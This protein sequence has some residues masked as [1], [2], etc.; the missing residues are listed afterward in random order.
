[1]EVRYMKL[2]SIKGADLEPSALWREKDR[3]IGKVGGDKGKIGDKGTSAD[4]GCAI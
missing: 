3:D 2:N 4:K 1:M